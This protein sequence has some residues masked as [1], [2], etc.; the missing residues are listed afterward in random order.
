MFPLKKHQIRGYRFGEPTFYSSFHLG[1]DYEANQ[2]ELY[3]PFD[4]TITTSIGVHSGKTITFKPDGQSVIIRLL[5][6]SQFVATG[7]VKAGTIIGITGNTGTSTAPHL[8][9]DISRVQLKINDPSNFIDPEKF[10]W[11]GELMNQAKIVKSKNSPTIYICYPVPSMDYLI[12][13]A[14]LEGIQLPQEIPNTD[15]LL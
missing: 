6:L 2:N 4:G 12:T 10:N 5:H 8:H 13:K 11:D 1:T 15:S 7:H 3:A 14:S 9:I